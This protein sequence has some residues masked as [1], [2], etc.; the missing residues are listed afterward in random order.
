MEKQRII[1]KRIK[2]DGLIEKYDEVAVEQEFEILLRNGEKIFGTATPTYME[3]LIL[4]S[5]FLARDLTEEELEQLGLNTI[6]EPPVKEVSAEE[7]FSVAKE[8]FENPGPLFCDTGCAHSCALIYQG[9]VLCQME[10]I[11]RYNALD[12]AIGYALKHKIPFSASYVFASGRISAGYIRKA[13]QAGFPMV[14]SRAA[15]TKAAVELAERENT[16]LI[17]FVR[18]NSGNIYYEGKVQFNETCR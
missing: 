17:G 10:D 5:R 16:T 9:R 6:S 8:C 2:E 1:V 4:S 11:G 15:V 3:E 12:K 18:K 14:V 13:I 7:I